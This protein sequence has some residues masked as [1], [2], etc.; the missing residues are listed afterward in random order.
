[1]ESFSGRIWVM[2][3]CDWV[4]EGSVGARY[5]ICCDSGGGSDL[6]LVRGPGWGERV[7]VLG[8]RRVVCGVDRESVSGS[9]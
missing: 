7:K 8:P 1:M 3:G 6:G 2:I 5:Q 4:A 9:G